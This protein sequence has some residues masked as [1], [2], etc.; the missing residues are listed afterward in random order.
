MKYFASRLT[1]KKKEEEVEIQFGQFL[2][3][4]STVFDWKHIYNLLFIAHILNGNYEQAVL[5]FDED[6]KKKLDLDVLEGIVKQTNEHSSFLNRHFK[7]ITNIYN[8]KPLVSDNTLRD[9]IK[10]ILN[11]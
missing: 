1:S 11:K 10:K 5:T 8:F 2:S 7:F 9:Q 6:L 3:L 4:L